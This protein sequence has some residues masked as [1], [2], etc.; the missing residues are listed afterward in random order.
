MTTGELAAKLIAEGKNTG[1]D[2]IYDLE[3]NYM[4]KLDESG[5]LADVSELCNENDFCEDTIISKNFVPTYR[6]VGAII[7]N[8][9]LLKEKGVAE[10]ERYD[11]LL[12]PEYIRVTDDLKLI[13]NVKG[14]VSVTEELYQ[15]ED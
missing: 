15:K 10:P 14:G 6:N 12:K 11:D 9:E 7:L 8:T 5:G 2:I 3:Y 4:L 1:C 13:I